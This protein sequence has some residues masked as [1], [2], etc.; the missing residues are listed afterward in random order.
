MKGKVFN[1]QRFSTKD[2]P[3]IRTTVFLNGCNLRCAWCQNPESWSLKPNIQL[4]KEKCV[5][6]RLCESLCTCGAHIFDSN[7]N[8]KIDMDKCVLCMECVTY[9]PTDALECK[10]KTYTADEL[11]K[12]VA[13]DI[14]YYKNSG[15]GVTMSGGEAMLQIDFLEEF[16]LKAKAQ[17]IHTAI[18]TAGAVAREYFERINPFVDLYLY[19]L[20]GYSDETHKKYVGSSNELVISNLKWLSDNGAKIMCRLPIIKGVNDGLLAAEEYAK[21]LST[22]KGVKSVKL[23]PY[24]NYGI[25][26]AYSIGKEMVEFEEPD[27]IEE[28]ANVYRKYGIKSED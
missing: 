16:L 1:I 18:D 28:I 23:I 5:N 17:G 11:L 21:L 13:S 24:H 14:D 25:N 7:G 3:G 2:G 27:N 19:D 4:F 22:L 26:K 8:H 9:C 15:G 6:C 12:I 20:K 10:S